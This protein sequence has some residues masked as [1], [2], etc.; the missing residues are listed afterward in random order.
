MGSKLAYPDQYRIYLLGSEYTAAFLQPVENVRG[1]MGTGNNEWFTPPEYL[2]L[3]REVLGEIDLDPASS[4]EAQKI[5][6]AKQFFDKG[7]DGLKQ[8]W[9]GRVFLNPPYGR[10]L[11]GLF[12]AKLAAEW[13]AGRI[14]SAITLTHNYTDP[15]WFQNDLVPSASAI[16]FTCGRIEF[17]G[18]HVPDPTQGQAFCYLGQD[19]DLFG[20]VFT[21]IGF[22]AKELLPRDSAHRLLDARG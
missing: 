14:E 20:E 15:F 4:A 18:D 12:T 22:V 6:R 9:H 3:V 11:I 7:T 17:L 10:S 2:V 16:C 19:V 13:K 8:E 1:T 21:S 5:V